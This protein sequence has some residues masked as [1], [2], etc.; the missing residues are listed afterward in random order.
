MM[1]LRR[2]AFLLICHHPPQL[3]RSPIMIYQHRC[4]SS[5][6]GLLPSQAYAELV[7]SQKITS[8]PHQIK[9]CEAFDDLH[10]QLETYQPP[11]P[12][13]TSQVFQLFKG[14]FSG[15]GPSA[16]ASSSSPKPGITIEINPIS[17]YS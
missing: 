15:S 4:L 6:S 12:P 11:D 9:V 2:N 3:R 8:D 1:A 5:S 17:K 16:E 14:I 7:K 13:S 10:K